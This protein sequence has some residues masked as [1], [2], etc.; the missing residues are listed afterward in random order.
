MRCR[1]IGPCLLSGPR[2][3][4]LRFRRNGSGETGN[5]GAR[6]GDAMLQRKLLVG[7]T[8]AGLVV[9]GG[10]AAMAAGGA[11]KHTTINAVTS[12]KFKINRYV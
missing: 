10:A 11:P 6:L 9:G 12:V 5:R 8:T 2:S 7:F 4:V 1:Q 3:D